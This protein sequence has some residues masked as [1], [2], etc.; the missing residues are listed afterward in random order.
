MMDKFWVLDIYFENFK[1]LKFY[2]VI[3]VNKLLFILL[4][5]GVYYN[6]R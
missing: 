6:V 2:K 1:S 5:G 4:D 3:M